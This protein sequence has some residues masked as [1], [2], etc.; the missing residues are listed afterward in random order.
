MIALTENRDIPGA[1]IAVLWDM[2]RERLGNWWS[3]TGGLEFG[4]LPSK[5]QLWFKESCS[6][7]CEAPKLRLV[8]IDDISFSLVIYLKGSSNQFCL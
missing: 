5:S 7:T 8:N 1:M 2:S 4:E 6:L 3:S